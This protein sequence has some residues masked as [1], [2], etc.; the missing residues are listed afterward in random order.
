M[1]EAWLFCNGSWIS[2]GRPAL[3]YHLIAHRNAT[4]PVGTVRYWGSRIKQRESAPCPPR[5]ISDLWRPVASPR[6]AIAV[7][8]LLRK[9]FVA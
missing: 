1:R 8:I 9:N 5:S 6:L 7:I 4:L 2:L 3:S